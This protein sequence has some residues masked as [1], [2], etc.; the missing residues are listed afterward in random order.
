MHAGID[1][2]TTVFSIDSYTKVA[3]P[4]NKINFN[5][6]MTQIKYCIKLYR[7]CFTNDVVFPSVQHLFR[8]FLKPDQKS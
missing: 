4:S 7:T 1:T 6:N 3:M 2:F 8:M 5:Q